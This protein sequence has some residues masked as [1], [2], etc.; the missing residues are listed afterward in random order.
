MVAKT[1]FVLQRAD[2]FVRD[3]LEVMRDTAGTKSESLDAGRLPLHHQNDQI[4]WSS[5]EGQ[6][7]RLEGPSKALV[8]TLLS[9]G[10]LRPVVVEKDDQIGE[11]PQRLPRT[12]QVRLAGADSV[13]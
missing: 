2:H 4:E 8:E 10:C 13:D 9:V 5:H 7:V 6:C 12:G 1:Q 3:G 11:D